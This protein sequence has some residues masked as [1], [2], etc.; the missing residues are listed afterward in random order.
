M[1]KLIKTTALLSSI[2]LLITW[3]IHFLVF[4]I[5]WLLFGVLGYS[6]ILSYT[7]FRKESTFQVKAHT[8][9]LIILGLATVLAA[10]AVLEDGELDEFLNMRLRLWWL[11][12][13]WFLLGL[14][15]YSI[16]VALLRRSFGEEDMCE[17]VRDIIIFGPFAVIAAITFCIAKE[18]NLNF[19]TKPLR[20]WLL[21]L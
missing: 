11:L 7:L 2:I 4:V 20:L 9:E 14:L 17:D 3:P 13:A 18:G 1:I 12:F 21:L 6:L 8:K 16:T 15:G 10:F 19:L 5:V